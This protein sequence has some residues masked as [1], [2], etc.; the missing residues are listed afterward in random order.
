[1]PW[2]LPKKPVFAANTVTRIETMRS[3][4]SIGVQIWL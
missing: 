3:N 4:L 1:M 2:S